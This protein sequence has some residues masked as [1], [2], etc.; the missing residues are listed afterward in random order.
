M[1]DHQFKF[2][3]DKNGAVP[4]DPAFWDYLLS[5]PVKDWRLIVYEQDWLNVELGK[6][7]ELMV[8]LYRSS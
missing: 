3:V 8:G 1:L 5:D 6:V 7:K 2:I 4:V